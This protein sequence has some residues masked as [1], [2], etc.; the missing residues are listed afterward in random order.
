MTRMTT[1]ARF[2]QNSDSWRFV[3]DG[4]LGHEQAGYR[5]GRGR[6]FTD[7]RGTNQ[8]KLVH[9]YSTHNDCMLLLP[10]YYGSPRIYLSFNYIIPSEGPGSGAVSGPEHPVTRP[11]PCTHPAIVGRR[12]Y[13]RQGSTLGR[14]GRRYTG[15][16]ST[17]G[18]P[19]TPST[20]PWVHHHDSLDHLVH[21]RGKPDG[22]RRLS[23]K[24]GPL[25]M[26]HGKPGPLVMHHGKP[27]GH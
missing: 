20:H 21:H 17:P 23:G 27:D 5:P 19:G 26:H 6:G 22:I 4:I 25:V 8:I 11:L 24:P 12:R 18:T 13:T 7:P 3:R 2:R 14:V 9:G 10:L 1:F 15:Q 16:G